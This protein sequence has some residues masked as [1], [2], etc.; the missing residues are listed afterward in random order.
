[1]SIKATWELYASRHCVSH[2]HQGIAGVMGSKASR[3]MSK[4]HEGI[5][6]SEASRG[7]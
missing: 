3:D 2:E 4:D 6:C 1:M 5:A 7:S